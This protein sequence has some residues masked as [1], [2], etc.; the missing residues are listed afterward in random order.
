MGEER[1]V[2]DMDKVIRFEACIHPGSKIRDQEPT[3][4]AW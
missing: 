1:D 2:G 3:Y 4:S